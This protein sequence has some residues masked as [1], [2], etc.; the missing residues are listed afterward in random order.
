[1]KPLGDLQRDDHGADNQGRRR[2]AKDQDQFF[3]SEIEDAFGEMMVV[4]DL[5]T[6][7]TEEERVAETLDFTVDEIHSA[8]DQ[9]LVEGPNRENKVC[10]IPPAVRIGDRI[11][12][13]ELGNSGLSDALIEEENRSLQEAYTR[14]D[15]LKQQYDPII[16]FPKDYLQ[17]FLEQ[18][19]LGPM[20]DMKDENG[21]NIFYGTI[22]REPFKAAEGCCYVVVLDEDVRLEPLFTSIKHPNVAK[23][24]GILHSRDKYLDLNSVLI[25]DESGKVVYAPDGER[26]IEEERVSRPS[27]EIDESVID[28]ID[29]PNVNWKQKMGAENTVAWYESRVAEQGAIPS[30]DV[31]SRRPMT[32]KY[33]EGDL[34]KNVAVVDRFQAKKLSLKL[35]MERYLQKNPKV[36]SGQILRYLLDYVD[37]FNE[38][39]DEEGRPKE[40]VYISTTDQS[41]GSPDVELNIKESTF[42]PR[43]KIGL[44]LSPDGRV[45]LYPMKGE[46]WNRRGYKEFNREIQLIT[47]PRRVHW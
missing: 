3:G 15:G 11:R 47:A 18:G 32:K 1:M 24:E 27:L 43:I 26:Y 16:T 5:G 6:P 44:K 10:H 2:A 25:L 35:N 31:P 4:S 21:E 13:E 42:S 46:G 37:K 45:Y 40:K 8:F 30:D 36:K 17:L 39:R 20:D 9:A 22:G 38:A 14:L 7:Q 34:K 12:L 29:Q 41:L 28:L 19:H 33:E 23:F